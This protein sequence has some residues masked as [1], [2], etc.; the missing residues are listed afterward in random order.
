MHW[1]GHVGLGFLSCSPLFA[2]L[3]AHDRGLLAVAVLVSA[4]GFGVLPDADELLAIPHRGL[5]HTVW[6]VVAVPIAVGGVVA[7]ALP[8]DS[9]G[10]VLAGGAGL[11]L[12]S[13]LVGDVVTP[14]GLRPF[15]PLSDWHV[16]LNLTLSRARSINRI[17][18]VVGVLAMVV[19][20]VFLR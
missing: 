19:P 17:L 2:W 7:V 1:R 5:T 15:A 12:V 4:M 9:A 14:M 8:A 20:I 6:F 18:L 3:L 10:I 16:S 11:A 13:H